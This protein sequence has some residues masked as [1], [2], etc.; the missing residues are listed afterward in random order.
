MFVYNS[1]EIPVEKP[2]VLRILEEYRAFLISYHKEQKAV[3]HHLRN[4]ANIFIAM[5]DISPKELTYDWL[6]HTFEY[7]GKAKAW[8]SLSGFMIGRK[9]IQA[10]SEN[11]MYR[12]QCEKYIAKVPESFQKCLKWYVEDKFALQERQ[13]SNNAS[14]PVKGSTI[15]SDMCSL[16]RMVRWITENYKTVTHWTDFTETIVNQYLLSLPASNRECSRK[17][18]YQFF[19]FAKRKR[20][21]FTIPITDYRTRE[22]P[23]VCEALTYQEQ[24]M[25]YHKIKEDGVSFPYEALLT[26]LCFLHAVQS[27]RIKEIKLS[28]VNVERKVIHMKDV[29]DIYLMPIEIVLLIEYMQMRKE[30]PNNESN[31]HL[32]IKRTRGDYLPDNP[33]AK[34]FI[35]SM[36]RKFSGFT[37]QV[38]RIT[39]LQEMAALNG[40]NF[41]REAYGISATH[42]GRYGSYEEYLVEEALKDAGLS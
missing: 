42:A 19:K 31:T 16:Y 37:P 7:Y 1:L 18:L 6:E 22:M 33:V 24:R 14:N 41:L 27:M 20:C 32:F 15:E 2:W 5:E 39:C 17:D 26:S 11:G 4:A 40:P 13:I 30:F 23:R 28:A 25:L 3:F 35:T 9:L 29:P 10:P 38:L 12:K 8:R 36:V 34:T 21:I